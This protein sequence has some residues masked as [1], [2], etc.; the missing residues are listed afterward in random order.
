M[1]K[2]WFKLSNPT[3]IIST[4]KSVGNPDEGF[5][6]SS[7][8]PEDDEYYEI[9]D[10]AITRNSQEAIDAVIAKREDARL[11]EEERITAKVRAIADNLPSR[12]QIKTAIN[13]AFPDTK[14]SAII[15]KLATV[16]YW[17]AKNQAD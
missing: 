7:V 8:V 10:G 11:A 1:T 6:E 15:T 14:Q 16:L 2:I 17:L 9:I 5:I 12:K 13:A 4:G 3:K